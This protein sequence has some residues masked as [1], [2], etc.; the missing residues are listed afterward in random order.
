LS[1]D[2]LTAPLQPTNCAPQ[3]DSLKT[4]SMA[5]IKLTKTEMK[6]QS[7]AL[8]RFLR[9][10]PMLLLKKQQLQ[11][12]ISAIAARLEEVMAR[13]AAERAALESWVSLF[14]S[15][16]SDLGRL[17]RLGSVVTESSNI[18]GVTIPVYSRIETILEPLDLFETPAWLDD[19]VAMLVRM[20]SIKA[21]QAVL[22]R[23]RELVVQELNTT[24]QRVNL[25]EKVKIPECRENIR[26]IKIAIGDAQTASVTR[27]KIAKGRNRK[28]DAENGEEA[29]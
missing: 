24:S 29:A 10:L 6:T 2:G 23:Q 14:A 27:G 1:V 9:F 25:F 18:A 15:S 22:N 11:A 28:S 20:L 4:P 16:S 17:V 8:K 19:A 13:E 5:K 3:R 12:E 21:E 7:D 26:L